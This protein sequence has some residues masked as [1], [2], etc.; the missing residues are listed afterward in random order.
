MPQIAASENETRT[1]VTGL[2]HY[3]DGHFRL[4]ARA[5]RTVVSRGGGPEHRRAELFRTLGR[6]LYAC[7]ERAWRPADLAAAA[8][9][10]RRAMRFL[11]N[12]AAPPVLL[13]VGRVHA[14][15]GSHGSAARI[16]ARV[17]EMYP[18]SPEL[19]SCVLVAAASLAVLRQHAQAA[20]YVKHVLGAPPTPFCEEI[21][22]LVLARLYSHSPRGVDGALVAAALDEARHRLRE[23]TALPGGSGRALDELVYEPTSGSSLAF[24]VV[25]HGAELRAAAMGA[26][27]EAARQA[28][29]GAALGLSAQVW[30]A[31]GHFLASAGLHWWAVDFFEHALSLAPRHPRV[32]VALAFS[33]AASNNLARAVATAEVAATALPSSRCAAAVCGW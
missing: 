6:A 21:L 18:R 13:E 27:R 20:A 3:R 26:L 33:Y 12:V 22:T 28:S 23:H 15:S 10:Y 31:V 19:P 9:A 8:E 5:L 32:L 4:A 2:R 1:L 14:A 16:F 7:F 24:D 30:E 17:I 25:A 29:T 11:V